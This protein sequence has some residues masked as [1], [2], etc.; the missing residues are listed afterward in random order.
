MTLGFSFPKALVTLLAWGLI[1]E[2]LF[3][4]RVNLLRSEQDHGSNPR[5]A[6]GPHGQADAGRRGTIGEVADQVEIVLSEGVVD[7]LQLAPR[8]LEERFNGRLP[9]AP[10]VLQQ[11]LGAFGSVRGL[12]HEF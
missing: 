8:A 1:F 6:A 5:G 9:A 2:A 7:G 12:E 11:A 10:A 4:G 3:R